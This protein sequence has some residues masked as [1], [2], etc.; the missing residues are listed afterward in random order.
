MLS[1][2]STSYLSSVRE[3]GGPTPLTIDVPFLFGLLR[4][5]SNVEKADL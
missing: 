4:A 2:Q 1:T 5:N 3:I